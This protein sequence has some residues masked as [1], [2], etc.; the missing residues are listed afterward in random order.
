LK[1]LASGAVSPFTRF[2]WP[3]PANGGGWVEAE[4]ELA[5]CRNG[6]H[7]CR[8]DALSRWLADELWW[9]ELAAVEIE[10]EGVLV[11]RRGRLLG[12]ISDWNESTRSAFAHW[13]LRRARELAAQTP[14]TK[15]AAMVEDIEHMTREATIDAPLIAF[16][17][18]KAAAES[19]PEGGPGERRRQ[20]EWLTERLGLGEGMLVK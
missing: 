19:D 5:V 17:S 14:G 10:R 12:R 20:S 16:C 7:A 3:T 6:V 13:C 1:F 4:G 8:G 15:I 9:I 2:S 11:A 18:A